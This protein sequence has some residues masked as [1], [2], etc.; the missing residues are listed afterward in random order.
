VMPGTA[1]LVMVQMRLIYLLPF[2]LALIQIGQKIAPSERGSFAAIKTSGKLYAW[3]YNGRGAL[4]Q[5]DTTNRSSPVQ[6]GS[7][8]N[9][10]KISC[11]GSGFI[12][13][14]G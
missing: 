11:R 14:R 13:V 8:T 2:R 9:W 1:A 5:G 10:T 7:G 4:G 12:G 3:G 6:V